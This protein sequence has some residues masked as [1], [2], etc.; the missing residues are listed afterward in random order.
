MTKLLDQ[1]DAL[2]EKAR[3]ILKGEPLRAIAY[4]SAVVIYL[5]ARALGRIEDVS[6]EA[7]VSTAF[8]AST[9]VIGI[10]ETARRYVYSAKTV[11]AIVTTPPTAAGPISAAMEEGVKP[12]A[13]VDAMDAQPDN[14]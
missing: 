7:A 3:D 1:I 13:L 8:A 14:Q 12:T 4:G 2:L 9:I 10:V 5:A 6:F 11:A